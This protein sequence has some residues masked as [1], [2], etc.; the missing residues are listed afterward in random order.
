MGDEQTSI[1]AQMQSFL[2]SCERERNASEHTLRNYRADLTQ[3]GVWFDA[4]G[5]ANLN[6][7]TPIKLRSYL[8]HLRKAHNY[9]ARSMARKTSSL[10]SFF[11]FLEEREEMTSN[12][13]AALRNP[14]RKRTLP[15]FLDEDQ[16][17]SL[18]DVPCDDSWAG[19]RDRAVISLLYDCGL[20][21]SELAGLDLNSVERERGLL[22]VFGKGR[23]QRR[24]PLIEASVEVIDAWLELRASPPKLGQGSVDQSALFL[25]QGG[26]RLT[27]R[28]VRRVLNA[29]IARA[30]LSLSV[31]PHMLRH[32]FATHLLNAGADLRDVQELLGH[33]HLSTTQIYTHV[34][35]ERMREVYQQAHPRA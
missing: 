11:R 24:V 16:A 30:A 27:D 35:H 23:K 2:A 25:N 3:F 33:A 14:K 5:V 10:R 9:A 28:S 12:P 15:K 18:L 1:D 29:W 26:S 6:A 4:S 32:S 31:H 13:A 17:I 34:S 7:L 21:V 8:A 20:R 22:Q 19:R